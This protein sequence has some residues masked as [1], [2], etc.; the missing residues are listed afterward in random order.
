MELAL[1]ESVDTLLAAAK[2]ARF[3]GENLNATL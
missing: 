1:F 3:I 2:V